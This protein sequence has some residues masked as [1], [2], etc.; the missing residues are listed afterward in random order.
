MF[1]PDVVAR[2]KSRV[3]ETQAAVAGLPPG[4][5]VGFVPSLSD[6]KLTVSAGIAEVQGQKIQKPTTLL[7]FSEWGAIPIGGFTYYLYLTRSGDYTVEN[8]EPVYSPSLYYQVHPTAQHRY[9]LALYL[10]SNKDIIYVTGTQEG[11]ANTVRVIREYQYTEDNE[12]DYSSSFTSGMT[13]AI[14]FT[15]LPTNTCSIHLRIEIGDA[16][17]VPQV[18]FKRTS[19]GT[20]VTRITASFA[21]A[22]AANIIRGNYWIPTSGNSVYVAF[23][24][25]DQGSNLY[26][27]GYKV[28]E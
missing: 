19:G 11:A 18:N 2:F 17:N 1:T 25:C 3:D 14:T 7:S 23:A 20:F 4:Y 15:E 6:G 22:G 27:I 26:V 13:A 8:Q 28:A 12:L 24:Q 9:I 16:G 5:R 21:D 10:D